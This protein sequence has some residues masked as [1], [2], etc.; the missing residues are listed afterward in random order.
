MVL[1]DCHRF[2]Q[3]LESEEW[4]LVERRWL[5]ASVPKAHHILLRIADNM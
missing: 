3:L 1:N 5:L 2:G 4:N